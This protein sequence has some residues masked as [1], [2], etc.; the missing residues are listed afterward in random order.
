MVYDYFTWRIDFILL[1]VEYVEMLR[2]LFLV[3]Y[4]GLSKIP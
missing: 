1:S 2:R 3:E 4:Y